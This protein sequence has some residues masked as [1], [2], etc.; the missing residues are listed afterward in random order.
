MN[1]FTPLHTTAQFMCFSLYPE[2]FKESYIENIT[3]DYNGAEIA[4]VMQELSAGLT[5]ICLGLLV[6]YLYDKAKLK[7]SSKNESVEQLLTEQQKQINRLNDII[8]SGVSTYPFVEGLSYSIEEEDKK[9][10]RFHEITLLK[11]KENDPEI[12]KMIEDSINAL[13]ARGESKIK[14][15]MDNYFYYEEVK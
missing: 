1:N 10:A 3:T 13:E 15:D 4:Y 11:I 6:N 8:E 2:E 9:L 5:N 7:F 14:E 12:R